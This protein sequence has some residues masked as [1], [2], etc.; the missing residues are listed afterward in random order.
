MSDNDSFT[1]APLPYFWVAVLSRDSSNGALEGPGN[2]GHRASFGKSRSPGTAVLRPHDLPGGGPRGPSRREPVLGAGLEGV[3]PHSHPPAA[4]APLQWT[5]VP[6][7]SIY[8]GD[9]PRI[10]QGTPSTIPIPACLH[11]HACKQT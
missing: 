5:L 1:K 6:S 9:T 8:V 11:S 7:L 2:M 3:R 4:A 10:P